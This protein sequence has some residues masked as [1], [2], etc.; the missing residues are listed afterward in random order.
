[1][2][3][4][5]TV[6]QSTFSTKVFLIDEMGQI[7]A[8]KSIKH[9]QNYPENNW[10]EHDASEIYHNL[11]TATENIKQQHSKL[12]QD[13]V[14]IAI[15]N[16]RETTVLWDKITQEPVTNAIVWQCRRTLKICDELSKYDERVEELTGLKMN[17]YFSATKLKWLLEHYP[18]KNRS[19]AFGTIESWLIYKLTHGKKHV[20][21][22]T[23]AS[24]TLLMNIET[25]K[26]DDELCQI[27]DI[28]QYLLP[29]IL[30]NDDIFGYSDI[31]GLLPYRVPICGI[32]GD[33]QASLYAQ[34]CFESGAMKVTLGTGSS[35]LMNSGHE[36]PEKMIGIVSAIAWCLDKE[37]T[38][39]REAIINCSCDTLNWLK[40]Q[41]HLFKKEDELNDIWDKVPNNDGVYLVPAFVG[42][43][44]PWWSNH[45]KASICGLSR[46][47]TY[48]HVLRAGLESIV[49]QI[50]DAAA[51]LMYD[52]QQKLNVDGGAVFNEGLLQFLSDILNMEV[53]VSLHCDLSAMGAYEIA[54]TR[55]LSKEKLI[56]VQKTYYPNM[57]KEDRIKNIEG[58][59][60]AVEGVLAMSEKER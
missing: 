50:F 22:V 20:S 29:E 37:V 44:V 27:F 54:R 13:I 6:D 16:Q 60:Y 21:D 7:H 19:Y 15:T 26:W 30:N 38:Y 5:L 10:V 49:Y 52:S 34:H 32:I 9:K 1:M 48:N 46:S 8:S 59:H 4:I 18:D 39:A 53:G 31:E 23:N 25:L 3:Y 55:L 45:A 28:P 43:S 24:R 33:S 40:D 35:L 12:F 56:N 58:W 41:M 47:H 42:L 51:T 57:S 36:K 14:G 17:P 11:V 2:K